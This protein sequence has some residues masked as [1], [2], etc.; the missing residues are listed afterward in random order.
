MELLRELSGRDA[1]DLDIEKPELKISLRAK[2]A[3]A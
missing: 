2:R 3:A 1:V